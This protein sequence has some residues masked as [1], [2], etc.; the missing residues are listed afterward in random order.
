MDK[1]SRVICML[2]YLLFFI[3]LLVDKDKRDYRHHANQ[4]LVLLI[5]TGL[6]IGLGLFIPVIG[7]FIILPFGS[8]FSFILLIIGMWHGLSYKTKELPLIGKVT[9]IK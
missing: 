8:I 2:A 3:P 9:L 6:V 4:G 5:F 1:K 7:W